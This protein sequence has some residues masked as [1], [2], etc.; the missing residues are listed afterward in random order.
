MRNV[1]LLLFSMLTI[2]ANGQTF[3]QTSLIGTAGNYGGEIFPFDYDN[4]NDLDLLISGKL[5]NYNNGTYTMVQNTGLPIISYLQADFGD[6]DGDG[7]IDMAY[8]GYVNSVN[9]AGIFKNNGNGTFTLIN[10]IIT[11]ARNGSVQWGDLDLDGDLDLVIGDE[12]GTKTL[13]IYENLNNTFISRQAIVYSEKFQLGDINNDGYLDILSKKY[14]GSVV[15]TNNGDF[16]FTKSNYTFEIIGLYQWIDW[17]H[18]GFLDAVINRYSNDEIV[19]CFNYGNESFVQE[20]YSYIQSDGNVFEVA[21]F[22]NDGLLDV[23]IDNY[24]TLRIYRNTGNN[25]QSLTNVGSSGLKPFCI[26][27]QNGD[28]NLDI[29]K[30]TDM[31]QN[32]DC[33]VNNLTTTNAA[34]AI[35]DSL[36]VVQS[37]PFLNLN[38]EFSTDDH[39]HE[40]SLTYDYLLWNNSSTNYIHKANSNPT[41]GFRKYNSPGLYRNG[42]FKINCMEFT[43]HDTLFVKAQ[44]IDNIL[45]GS[46]FSDID[47]ILVPLTTYCGEAI[48]INKGSSF[49]RTASVNTA[50]VVSYLWSPANGVSNDSINNPV[51]SPTIT[52]TYTVKV[53]NV[54]GD[55]ATDSF[56]VFVK[57]S[58]YQPTNFSFSSNSPTWVD[59]NKDGY[60]DV[61]TA[62]LDYSGSS[63]P[64]FSLF[65]NNYVSFLPVLNTGISISSQIK[66]PVWSDINLDGILD[67]LYIQNSLYLYYGNG[68][69]TYTLGHT[70]SDFI[71]NE[72]TVN[73]YDNDGD[74][75]ILLIGWEHI[76]ALNYPRLRL[77]K[78]NLPD[79]NSFTTYSSIGITPVFL[80]KTDWGDFNNDG[81]AD[82][83]LT[84]YDNYGPKTIVAKNLGNGQFQTLDLGIRE[85]EF[86]DCEWVD[87]DQDGLLDFAIMGL[88]DNDH[89]T[90]YICK[91]V[92]QDKFA[93]VYG[94]DLLQVRNCTMDWG[95]YDNDGDK[96]IAITG[97]DNTN[98][99]FAQIIRNENALYFIPQNESLLYDNQTYI[100]FGDYD[101]DTDLDLIIRGKDQNNIFTTRIFKN[102]IS[103]TNSPPST[104]TNLSTKFIDNK[105]NFHWSKSI[106]NETATEGLTYNLAI[107]LNNISFDI[108]NPQIAATNYQLQ[109]PDNGNIGSNNFFKL[110]RSLQLGDTV[111]WSVQAVDNAYL[112]SAPAPLSYK[113]INLLVE[114]P[115]DTAVL[116]LDTIQ[117]NPLVAYNGSGTLSYHWSPA[118]D[119]SDTTVSNP[120]IYCHDTITYSLTVTSSLGDTVIDHITI[121]R[122]DSIFVLSHAINIPTLKCGGMKWADI[123]NDNDQDLIIFGSNGSSNIYKTAVYKNNSSVFTEQVGTG[124]LNF[125]YGKAD[126]GD[127]DNDGDQDLLIC[128][129]SGYTTTP[130]SKVYNNNGNSFVELTYLSIIGLKYC[131][132]LWVDYN[133]DGLLDISVSGFDNSTNGVTAVYKNNG[134]GGF[135]LQSSISIDSLGGGDMDW[136]DFNND[137]YLD[138][139]VSGKASYTSTAT[140]KL[141]KNNGDNTFT[142]VTPANLPAEYIQSSANNEWSD[143]DNDGDIDLLCSGY[144]YLPAILINNGNNSFSVGPTFSYFRGYASW[145]DF[146]N[147]GW[148]DF[149]VNNRD[150]HG[151]YHTFIMQNNGNGQFS[152]VAEL[153]NANV[154][155]ILSVVDFNEDNKLDFF[156]N[157]AKEYQILGKSL[158]YKNIDTVFNTAP[159]IPLIFW[160]STNSDSLFI[161]WD[162]SSDN[163]STLRNISYNLHIDTGATNHI[164]LASHSDTTTGYHRLVKAGNMGFKNQFS[165]PLNRFLPGS[166][167][168]IKI[169]SIDQA[170]MASPF[171]PRLSIKAL[172]GFYNAMIN[173]TLCQGDSI[174]LLGQYFSSPGHYIIS[175]SSSALTDSTINLDLVVVPKPNPFTI[176]GDTIVYE[177]STAIYSAPF[178]SSITYL[179]SVNFGQ[180]VSFPSSNQ[181]VVHW[182]TIGSGEVSAYSY[183]QYHCLSDTSHLPVSVIINSLHSAGNS[184]DVSV[185]PVPT[186]AILYIHFN[187]ELIE[188][189]QI[190]LY[191]L[192]GKLLGLYSDLLNRNFKID[193]SS[194]GK[195]IYHLR[196][197]TKDSFIV[198]E[199][200]VN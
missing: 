85:V 35:P 196:I 36:S 52:T 103:K 37:G 77:Y 176:L 28:G 39:T 113:A 55:T 132:C 188:P 169:Q 98:S 173:D 24:Q 183:N 54:Q 38:Y 66:S 151:K 162:Y 47:T 195:G 45:K 166:E 18:D 101:N 106:D 178:D 125:N 175:N 155:G 1:I 156:M 88:D 51:F 34:P 198:K 33:Y 105:L 180:S 136:I 4:D 160:A 129:G 95:D 185:F 42:E 69:L 31:Y 158:L 86:A 62:F 71:G 124:I 141:F 140:L 126:W 138:V 64:G 133:S 58:V 197:I 146:N 145:I 179:W 168:H 70:F 3:T 67:V 14:W 17:N 190:Y 73:D 153:L 83:L 150:L 139:S 131:T 11:P 174:Y 40:K 110:N 97:K 78:N 177:N 186:S 7:W 142:D 157:G 127:Y 61:S 107:G 48:Q 2:T 159:S 109:I 10:S 170:Y 182:N 90:F 167:I 123:D 112:C 193:F 164:I 192:N 128:G 116:Y 87:Y 59:V 199:I 165:L 26:I 111:F 191:D 108:K 29:I 25:L 122:V 22:D 43:Y 134:S 30:I 76:N 21:D 12:L 181:V 27:D 44:A 194:F 94:I 117:M 137:G 63:A 135:I 96:D 121:N 46:L 20:T 130:T 118:I 53:S 143:F 93:T 60:L 8:S 115:Q 6:Y 184:K 80:T 114:L 89:T 68:D 102:H 13:K 65:K 161:H 56:V 81:Y 171:S 41:N 119:I 49:Q 9:S 100:E 75:D 154:D 189:Y 72:V 50:G 172:N 79:S 15:I 200:I 147:D 144:D 32:I 82:L 152:Q 74:M 84:G 148:E 23:I 19:F 57:D 163:Q 149:V 187:K 91:N 99:Y 104:P 120:Y 16:Q 5:F 92:G